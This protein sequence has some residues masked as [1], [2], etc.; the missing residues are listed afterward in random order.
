V[1]DLP[2]RRALDRQHAVVEFAA[3]PDRGRQRGFARAPQRSA[4]ARAPWRPAPQQVARGRERAR[5]VEAVVADVLGEREDGRF[6]HVVLDDLFLEH[7]RRPQV[8]RLGAL[9]DD[10]R[11]RVGVEGGHFPEL[12][13]NACGRWILGARQEHTPADLEVCF[14]R[15]EAVLAAEA[16]L[17]PSLGRVPTNCSP[18]TISRSSKLLLGRQL[19]Q[20]EVLPPRALP[21]AQEVA[22]E[23]RQQRARLLF[24]AAFLGGGRPCSNAARSASMRAS[25][26][27]TSGCASSGRAVGAAPPVLPDDV[28]APLL[29][30]V[31]QPLGREA[32]VL[33]VGRDLR[34]QRVGDLVAPVEFE[35]EFEVAP[36]EAGRAQIETPAGKPIRCS[37]CFRP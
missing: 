20:P 26:A 24:A 23:A 36:R 12:R 35:R 14:L 30:P 27:R 4:G 25:L 18:A 11:L 9:L 3:E 5:V 22:A 7:G 16:R 31:A 6:E 32:V 29:E 28:G 21:L 15:W 10:D 13:A 19:A 34:A 1:K 33:V 37:N 17:P 8:L 2:D